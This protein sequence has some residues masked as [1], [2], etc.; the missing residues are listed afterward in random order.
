M[1][2]IKLKGSEMWPRSEL[3]LIYAALCELLGRVFVGMALAHDAYPAIEGDSGLSLLADMK[4]ELAV[5]GPCWTR[6][7]ER[8]E[9][10]RYYAGKIRKCRRNRTVLLLNNIILSN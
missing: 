7:V 6:A 3:V 5:Q 2:A 1:F 8:L 10:N 4:A 9:K